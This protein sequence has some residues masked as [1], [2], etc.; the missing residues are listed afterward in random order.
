MHPFIMA[1]PSSLIHGYASV[2]LLRLCSE[3][4]HQILTTFWHPTF[5]QVFF[6]SICSSVCRACFMS[7]SL[8]NVFFNHEQHNLPAGDLS[9]LPLFPHLN[10]FLT[11]PSPPPAL[12][13]RGFQKTE[14]TRGTDYS[15][16]KQIPIYRAKFPVS[17]QPL[18]FKQGKSQLLQEAS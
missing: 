10:F 14:A 4:H 3:T 16:L 13:V 9:Q 2:S 15:I 8:L 18:E 12:L 17:S 11:P 1:C 6:L 5:Q 7:Q